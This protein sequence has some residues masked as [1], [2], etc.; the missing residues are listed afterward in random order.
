MRYSDMLRQRQGNRNRHMK[1]PNGDVRGGPDPRSDQNEPGWGTPSQESV[2]GAWPGDKEPK[3]VEGLA[4]MSWWKEAEARAAGRHDWNAQ[5]K[6][7]TPDH[8]GWTTPE[9]QRRNPEP[10]GDNN[11]RDTA[12]GSREA[13]WRRVSGGT[14]TSGAKKDSG[15]GNGQT[16]SKHGG[17]QVG[18]NTGSKSQSGNNIGWGD[19]GN[20]QPGDNESKAGDDRGNSGQADDKNNQERAR[21]NVE[22]DNRS[23]H[24]SRSQ[25]KNDNWANDTGNTGGNNWQPKHDNANQ[26]DNSWG[27]DQQQASGNAAGGWGT[28]GN[29]DNN[30]N[31][32]NAN[33]GSNDDAGKNAN[34]GWGADNKQPQDNN[35]NNSWGNDD[36]KANDSWGNDDQKPAYKPHS[37]KVRRPS[38]AAKSTAGETEAT[39]QMKPY[40]S[41]WNK[42]PEPD[43]ESPSARRNPFKYPAEPTPAISR[44]AV[45]HSVSSQV[46]I[47]PGA[48]FF[49]ETAKP[50]YIDSMDAPYAIFRFKYRSV[51]HLENKFGTRIEDDPQDLKAKVLTM[52]KQDLMDEYIRRK[53][54]GE[55]TEESKKAAS[56]RSMPVGDKVGNW[57]DG[58]R[59]KAASVK[60]EDKKDDDWGNW[61][62]AKSNKS[63]S[64]TYVTV[65]SKGDKNLKQG[66]GGLRNDGGRAKNTGW[67]DNGGQGDGWG[68]GAQ[69]GAAQGSGGVAW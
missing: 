11:V 28:I 10:D 45:H 52:T 15:W 66:D 47:G 16:R 23:H 42:P 60:A 21:T 50:Q 18:W 9:S 55:K 7:G 54:R 17:S 24:R 32:D 39:F 48:D 56:A 44:T 2:P 61:G 65:L 13:A 53:I 36:N 41:S 40:W 49:H 35:V 57:N 8:T 27:Y 38:R 26:N 67:G 22:K 46:R 33:W 37:I 31:N 5:N 34:T 20:K 29:A 43:P 14:R 30:A 58:N 3:S 51:E 25:Q 64:Y 6:R 68:S 1:R 12:T 59:G 19:T 62:E 69:N 63:N 4:N